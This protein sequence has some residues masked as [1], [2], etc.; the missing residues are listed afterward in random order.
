MATSIPACQARCNHQIC[1][2]RIGNHR[3]VCCHRSGCICIAV[4]IV[5]HSSP[6]DERSSYNCGHSWDDHADPVT[7][8]PCDSST[9]VTCATRLYCGCPVHCH[10]ICRQLWNGQQQGNVFRTTASQLLPRHVYRKVTARSRLEQQCTKDQG[11]ASHESSKSRTCRCTNY[12]PGMQVLDLSREHLLPPGP[13]APAAVVDVHVAVPVGH[14]PVGRLSTMRTPFALLRNTT[15]TSKLNGSFCVTLVGPPFT[16][17]KGFCRA[18]RQQQQHT[19]QHKHG[20]ATQQHV[21]WC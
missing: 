21:T 9:Q 16:I 19:D 5:C 18:Q 4:L 11:R 10:T 17:V 2:H 1:T 3:R 6:V 13:A 14:N 12:N 8:C 20:E 7:P 15:L